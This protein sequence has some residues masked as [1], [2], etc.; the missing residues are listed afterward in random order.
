MA[1]QQPF[2]VILNIDQDHYSYSLYA[3]KEFAKNYEMDRFGKGFG[4]FLKQ[5]EVELYT[6]LLPVFT[7][8]LDVGAGAGKL[9]EKFAKRGQ[10]VACDASFEMLRNARGMARENHVHYDVVVCDA[11]H[12]CFKDGAFDAVVSS[13]V[14][15]H[16]L[17][18]RKMVSE[19]CRVSSAFVCLDFPPYWS[20]SIIERFVRKLSHIFW[21]KV[22]SY[23]GFIPHRVVSEFE[24]HSCRPAAK[25]KSFFLPI[26]F[27]RILNSPYIT[28]KM[29][30]FWGK[31]GLTGLFGNPVTY[32]FERISNEP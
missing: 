20:F 2:E 4:K 32:K 12:L 21:R 28:L 18:W 5:Y 6:R 24:S 9:A 13:R 25:L 30:R 10:V 19:L 3:D 26:S 31:V 15:M 8:L 27:Y 22:Q 17:D 7:R 16:V 11:H 23:R 1:G 14:L 29:E